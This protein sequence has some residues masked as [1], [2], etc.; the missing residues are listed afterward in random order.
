[1]LNELEKQFVKE[2]FTEKLKQEQIKILEDAM[3]IKVEA[4]KKSDDPKKWAKI[5]EEKQKCREQIAQL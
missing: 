4:L 1:M 5:V 2:Q 3:W